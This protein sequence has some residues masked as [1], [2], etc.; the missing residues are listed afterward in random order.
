MF[1]IEIL[2]KF[3]EI[4]NVLGKL[5]T[6][7]QV[8]ALPPSKQGGSIGPAED[9]ETVSDSPGNATDSPS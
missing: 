5:E 2:V 1:D 6:N 3:T 7:G 8:L 4:Q 9:G